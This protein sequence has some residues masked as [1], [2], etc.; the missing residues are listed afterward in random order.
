[1]DINRI[2]IQNILLYLYCFSLSLSVLN[3]QFLDR[4]FSISFVF[5]IIFLL[6][7][8]INIKPYLD[9][10]KG[11]HFIYPI[12]FYV[13]LLSFVSW[14]NI[15]PYSSR[16]LDVTLISNILM[17]VIILNYFVKHADVRDK[18]MLAFTIGAVFVAFL[19]FM[20]IGAEINS[21][22][23][24]S[25]MG[26]DIVEISIKMTLALVVILT[27][28]FK[29][30][31]TL[32]MR[33]F[34]LFL[35]VSLLLWFIIQTGSRTALLI[36]LSN[37]F[38]LLFFVRKNKKNIFILILIAFLPLILFYFQSEVMQERVIYSINAE[39]NIGNDALGGRLY[40]W[41]EMIPIIFKNILIGH[42][43]SGLDYELYKVFGQIVSP[44]N[45]LLE[46][47]LK[48][49]IIGFLSYSLFLFRL[50]MSSYWVY[51]Y[52]DNYAHILLLFVALGIAAS[53]H[54][55]ISKIF[56]LIMAYIASSFLLLNYKDE[57]INYRC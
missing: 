23:R 24:L 54:P 46:A 36:V 3:F 17:F 31:I 11:Q 29:N 56:W 26:S 49:G 13:L 35:S 39:T 55:S 47:F 19:S 34:W 6:S 38:L 37:L 4:V 16:F 42:G 9:L 10:S 33:T 14:V 15:N 44:H 48:T 52:E 5:S 51:K 12:L 27:V 8:S 32:K 2:T 7:L 1:M 25:W 22:G 41:G 57:N 30:K 20:N 53:I 45:A 43:L 21:D 18:A 40:L 50:S 28:I